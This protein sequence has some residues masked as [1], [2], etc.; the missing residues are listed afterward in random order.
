MGFGGYFFVGVIGVFVF[1]ICV[2]YWSFVC[3]RF[4]VIVVC[5]GLD[6]GWCL[7]LFVFVSS[8]SLGSVER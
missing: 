3:G 1:Y 5:I 2:G 7:D 4:F 6:I 8:G